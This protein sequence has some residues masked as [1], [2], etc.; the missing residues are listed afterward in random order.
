MELVLYVSQKV[1]S[2]VE[3]QTHQLVCDCLCDYQEEEEHR[4][5]IPDVPLDTNPL[6]VFEATHV[7]ANIYRWVV[8]V[9]WLKAH[10]AAWYWYQTIKKVYR[11]TIPTLSSLCEEIWRHERRRR[12]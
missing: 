3:W 1:W 4:V 11:S 7:E 10:P 6:Q 12:R 2:Y 5:P 9:L 8:F